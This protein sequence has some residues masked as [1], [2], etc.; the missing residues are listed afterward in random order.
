MLLQSHSSI[1]SSFHRVITEPDP[2]SVC[3][4][5]IPTTSHRNATSTPDTETSGKTTQHQQLQRTT[6][7]IVEQWLPPALSATAAVHHALQTPIPFPIFSVLWQPRPRI[8]LSDLFTSPPT[9]TSVLPATSSFPL[10]ARCLPELLQQRLSS[11]ITTKTALG[12]VTCTMTSSPNWSAR[13]R[14]FLRVRLFSAVRP[15]FP[16]LCHIRSQS[17]KDRMTTFNPHSQLVLQV[18]LEASHTALSIPTLL[19]NSPTRLTSGIAFTLASSFS[20]TSLSLMIS[21]CPILGMNDLQNS[22][23]RGSTPSAGK[24]SLLR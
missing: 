4:R 14:Q 2:A 22:S 16:H 6:S 13:R 12:T 9:I 7:C 18:A 21:R 24:E 10:H 8:I 23:A 11:F 17:R 5:I 3:V 19:K 15:A 20:S 1:F